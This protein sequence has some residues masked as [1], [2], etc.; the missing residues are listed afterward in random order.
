MGCCSSQPPAEIVNDLNTKEGSKNKKRAKIEDE[1]AAADARLKLKRN[2]SMKY[3]LKQLRE[4]INKLEQKNSETTDGASAIK[5]KN[6]RILSMRYDLKYHADI[7]QS[8]S[9]D[10]SE[11][12]MQ[13][14]V[15]SSSSYRTTSF[16]STLSVPV[17]LP[18][19]S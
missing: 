8:S 15:P 16:L 5:D 18:E 14:I 19:V 7:S 12:P 11:I 1:E 4:N 6:G 2:L 10:D 13:G 9:D 17:W 3:D